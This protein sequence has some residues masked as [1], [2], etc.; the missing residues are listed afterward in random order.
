MSI[1]LYSVLSVLAQVGIRIF[2]FCSLR[3]HQDCDFTVSESTS[4]WM[5]VVI[6][7]LPL[8]WLRSWLNRIGAGLSFSIRDGLQFATRIPLICSPLGSPCWL[9]LQRFA[10][11]LADPSVIKAMLEQMFV[12]CNCY[13]WWH[14]R[15]RI[16]AKHLG[17]DS[18][19]SPNQ[20]LATEAMLFVL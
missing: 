14:H 1:N 6:Y 2:G 4:L 20:C 3:F 11:H 15:K 12:L 16:A 18:G 19:V 17:F 9:D 5:I 10:R 8:R 13:F 7:D